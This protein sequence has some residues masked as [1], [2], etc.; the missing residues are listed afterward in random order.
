MALTL[1]EWINPNNL[2]NTTTVYSARP[3]EFDTRYT[4][5]QCVGNWPTKQKSG[6]ALH[7]LSEI[8]GVNSIS[9]SPF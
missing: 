9:I 6:K 4:P 3:L 1:S 7:A 5:L 8:N 2:N